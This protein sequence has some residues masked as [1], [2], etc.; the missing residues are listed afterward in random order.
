MTMCRTRQPWTR[1]C[2]KIRVREEKEEKGLLQTCVPS[3][4]RRNQ[5]R[6]AG[7]SVPNVTFAPARDVA[8]TW[9]S[10][11][12]RCANSYYCY[13]LKMQDQ[14]LQRKEDQQGLWLWNGRKVF[15][16]PLFLPSHSS[17]TFSISSTL[18]LTFEEKVELQTSSLYYLH[19]SRKEG[20]QPLI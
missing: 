10:R 12:A 15:M 9:P 17:V 2:S 18:I 5:P 8:V 19:H 6:A 7:R 11:L 20:H 16:I 3:A 1:A 4:T 14:G 13:Y